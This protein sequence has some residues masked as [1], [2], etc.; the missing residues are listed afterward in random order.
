[1]N[2]TVCLFLNLYL[3]LV[4]S[5]CLKGQYFDNLKISHIEFLCQEIS[6]YKLEKE[7]LRKPNQTVASFTGGGGQGGRKWRIKMMEVDSISLN[8]IPVGNLNYISI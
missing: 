1:M 5:H 6:T 3:F 7:F 2:R 8:L 4:V